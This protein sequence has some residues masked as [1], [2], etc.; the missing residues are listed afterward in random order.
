[1]LPA[2]EFFVSG[3]R[4]LGTGPSLTENSLALL[5]RHRHVQLRE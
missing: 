2:F 3:N 1:M 5:Q 4:A